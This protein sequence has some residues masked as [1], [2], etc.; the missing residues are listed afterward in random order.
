MRYCKITYVPKQIA[1]FGVERLPSLA[2]ATCLVALVTVVRVGGGVPLAPVLLVQNP[3]RCHPLYLLLEELPDPDFE[4]RQ[5][6]AAREHT[7]RSQLHNPVR[8]V[9]DDRSALWPNDPD[10]PG[11]RRKVFP[12]LGLHVAESVVRRDDLDCEVRWER[13]VPFW[14]STFGDP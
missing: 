9:D 7:L 5:D 13:P 2:I 11:A 4:T 3:V 12:H 6:I 8:L 1:L 14:W 10:E